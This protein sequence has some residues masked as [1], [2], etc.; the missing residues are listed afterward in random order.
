MRACYRG[1]AGR[2]LTTKFSEWVKQFRHSGHVKPLG[3][4]V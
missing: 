3:N 1:I 2:A 4:V